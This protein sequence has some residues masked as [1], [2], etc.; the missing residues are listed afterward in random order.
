LYFEDHHNDIEKCAADA[1]AIE[2]TLTSDKQSSEE[3]ASPETDE[4]A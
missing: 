4:A 2:R 1:R 3:S